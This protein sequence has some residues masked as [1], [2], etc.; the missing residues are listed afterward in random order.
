MSIS[1]QFA[2]TLHWIAGFVATPGFRA[3]VK[4]FVNDFYSSEYLVFWG[5]D[6][7]AL[8]TLQPPR[9]PAFSASHL[10]T[11]SFPRPVLLQPTIGWRQT[12]ADRCLSRIPPSLRHRDATSLRWL[13]L[14]LSKFN[15][16]KSDLA[17]MRQPNDL[18]N[19][20]QYP[21]IGG[22]HAPSCNLDLIREVRSRT[23]AQRLQTVSCPITGKFLADLFGL[24]AKTYAAI[25]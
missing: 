9:E 8:P 23:T 21:T 19:N 15:W 25:D 7:P 1:A 24:G 3:D 11:L 12:Q 2:R 6:A 22:S 13:S 14:D 4:R 5:K 18:R 20:V 17:I 16:S 10:H